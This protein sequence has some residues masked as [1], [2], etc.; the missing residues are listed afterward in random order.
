MSRHLKSGTVEDMNDINKE[1]IL[2][3]IGNAV[4]HIYFLVLLCRS[5]SGT[6][7]PFEARS[8]VIPKLFLYYSL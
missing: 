1:N 6:F 4:L 7:S 5:T 2:I 8:K 3:F